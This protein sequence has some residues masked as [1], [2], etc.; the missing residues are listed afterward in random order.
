MAK[1]LS[2]KEIKKIQAKKTAQVK[3]NQMIKK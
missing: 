3:S 1:K 2:E